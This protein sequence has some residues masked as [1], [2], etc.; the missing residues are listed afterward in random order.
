M[1]TS[2]VMYLVL[3]R[4]PPMRSRASVSLDQAGRSSGR[5]RPAY[6]GDRPVEFHAERGGVAPHRREARVR[7]RLETCDLRLAGSHSPGELHLGQSRGAATRRQFAVAL[8][9]DTL[10]RRL[11]RVLTNLAPAL[12][13]W[14]E[15][16]FSQPIALG[17]TNRELHD[18][19]ASLNRLR[20]YLVDLVGTI[21]GKCRGSRRQQ[22]RPRRTEQWP[23]RRRRTPG[24]RYR[25]DP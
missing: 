19:E 12:S 10:Q 13:T 8:L 25:A 14:A 20:A 22:P 24:R 5:R 17:K 15:G 3:R 4:A 6:R 23:A 16:D 21:R 2:S 1:D 7:P 18:I 9:I 11:A